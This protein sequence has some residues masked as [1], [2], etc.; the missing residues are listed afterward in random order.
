MQ[1]LEKCTTDP[2]PK[3]KLF[4]ILTLQIWMGQK[5]KTS[6]NQLLKLNKT[7]YLMIEDF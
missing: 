5:T 6:Q 2:R 4:Q 3:K 7:R 1:T